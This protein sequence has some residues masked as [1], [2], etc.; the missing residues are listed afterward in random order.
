MA[1]S[2]YSITDGIDIDYDIT[3]P[4]GVAGAIVND[5]N[6]QA[7]RDQKRLS[8][9]SALQILSCVSAPKL[10]TPFGGKC[11]LYTIGI[12]PTASGKDI[13]M[14]YTKHALSAVGVAAYQKIPSA[15]SI[16]KVLIDG[17]GVAVYI[18][19][20]VHGF[21]S[22]LDDP[23]SPVYLKEIGESI[24]NLYTDDKRTFDILEKRETKKE[25]QEAKKTIDKDCRDTGIVLGS[26]EHKRR[27]EEVDL[28]LNTILSGI[29][30][31][32]C[33][34]SGYS[35][36][37]N[38]RQLFSAKNF[39]SGLSGRLLVVVGDEEVSRMEFRINRDSV[40]IDERIS[41]HLSALKNKRFG[42]AQFLDQQAINAAEDC[43]NRFELYVND[44]DVGSIARRSAELLSRVYTVL[45][46]GD[47]GK[48]KRE[49]VYWSF[50][51]VCESFLDVWLRYRA[52][53]NEADNS[54]DARW[55]EIKDK[56]SL[57]LKGS[58]VPKPVY[59]SKIV[60]TVFRSKKSKL[61]TLVKNAFPTDFE[62]GKAMIID[63]ALAELMMNGAVNVEGGNKVSV[64]DAKKFPSTQAPRKFIDIYNSVAML[65]RPRG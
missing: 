26:G 55:A 34:L 52:N 12:A 7:F 57:K 32:F 63:I 18:I 4:P 15:K 3:R 59:K 38:M 48:I 50:M 44:Q 62:S 13:G 33:A 10:T 16:N 19:D 36:P 60:E 46:V 51:F 24:L 28:T 9:L 14:K 42:K 1:E 25:N 64:M 23:R 49:H 47:G 30:M 29:S 20:E 43:H 11:N 27:V 6:R 56:I 61:N 58:T 5:I 35:T 40:K 41:Q 39:E 37:D 31:P 22:S 65:F 2:I 17:D 21:F 45:S 54:Y 8:V 53:V